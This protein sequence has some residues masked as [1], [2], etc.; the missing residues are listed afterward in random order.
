MSF[1]DDASLVFLAGGAAGKDGKAYNLKPVEELSSTEVVINGDFS[2][3]GPGADGELDT[4]YGNYGWNTVTPSAGTQEGTTTISN[5]VLKLTNALGETDSRAYA[6]DGVS[7]RNVITTNT[8]Y[9]LVY[10]IVE[11][12]GCTSFKIYN[13]GGV[14]EDAPSS[15]GTHTVTLR[16]TSNQLFLF[17][18]KTESS[19]ISID[20]VSIR[21]ITN[22]AADFTFTRGTNL[23]ATRVGKDGY[24]EKGRENLLLHS[25]N[26]NSWIVS[27]GTTVTS[28]QTGYDGSSDA[29]QITKDASGFR[30]VRQGLTSPTGVVTFSVYMKAG[31]LT[32]ATLRLLSSPDA[33][34]NFNLNTGALVYK[35][36]VVDTSSTSIGNGWYRYSMTAVMT[37]MAEQVIYPDDITATNAGYIYIQ[38]AQLEQGLVATDYIETGATTAT[39]GLLE[40]EP[41]FDYTGGGCPA[42]LMEPTRTN[43][44]EQSEYFD[45]TSWIDT[46]ATRDIIVTQVSETTPDGGS[47]AYKIQGTD[48]SNQLAAFNTI[49]IGD[50]VTNSI[51]VKRVSGTGDVRLRDVN[52]VG[53]DFSL[54]AADG[55]KRIDVTGTATSTSG[56]FYV[57]LTTYTD[58][59]LVWGAQQEKG[60]FVTSYMPNYGAAATVTR[61]SDGTV[62]SSP[63][64]LTGGYDLSS[65]WSLFVDANSLK[66]TGSSSVRFLGL[67]T[68]GNYN[69]QLYLNTSASNLGVNPYL[70]NNGDYVFG[71]NSNA[72][73]SEDGFKICLT[74]DAGTNKIS[75]YINGSLYNSTTSALT[76]GD[77]TYGYIVGPEYSPTAT[78]ASVGLKQI[79]FAPTAFS[80]NDSEI[81]TGATSYRSFN[82][83]RSALN[84]T[85][86]E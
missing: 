9:K 79:L 61:D 34:A 51:Y 7:S 25:N 45:H 58:E 6:T 69:V 66:K 44:I 30:F 22:Q 55:W 47:V 68:S 63:S 10:T 1:Y 81:L 21:E 67:H 77:E 31:T 17:F 24:I 82:V 50:V 62:G 35:S 14:Q 19:S 85:A 15:V 70:Q 74:Y 36:N 12:N 52:N 41:R 53:T 13:A 20:N 43:L 16:N 48:V 2:I 71:Y 84:Y 73:G 4:S 76:F 26:F 59:I 38:D 60:E 5:G 57:N 39:A 72:A 3:D 78:D 11:N 27:G 18:N 33:R 86:Y 29:Y 8:Y 37:T 83:M 42:L 49:V 54:S 46:S 75:Y 65:S 40:D 56:R 23:T 80:A 64:M 28:G 32:T